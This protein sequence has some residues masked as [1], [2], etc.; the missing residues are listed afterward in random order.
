MMS[1][2]SL[3]KL[4]TIVCIGLVLSLTGCKSSKNQTTPEVTQKSLEELA[5]EKLGSTAEITF[6]KNKSHA[7]VS[8]VQQDKNAA[9]ASVAFFVYETSNGKI[10]LEDFITQGKVAWLENNLIRVSVISGVPQE[11]ASGGYIF[12]VTTEKKSQF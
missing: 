3:L 8:R 4:T 5:T 6:N 9:F 2:D 12:N 11:N 1:I 10:I 7:L